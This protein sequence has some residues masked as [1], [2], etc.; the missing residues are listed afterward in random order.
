VTRRV[1]TSFLSALV[2]TLALT[3]VSGAKTWHVP[4]E[5]ATIPA[6]IDSAAAGDTILVASGIYHVNLDTGG[7][8]LVF[9]SEAGAEQTILDG[10]HLNS[11]VKLIGGG[12]IDGFTIQNGWAQDAGSAGDGGGI[13]IWSLGMP[14]P[15]GAVRHC[16]IENN[17]AGW[18]DEGLGGGIAIGPVADFLIY[19][20]LV[21]DNY[22][23]YMGGGIHALGSTVTIEACRVLRNGTHFA[24]GGINGGGELRNNIIAESWSDWWGGGVWELSQSHITII[25]GNTI[26]GNFITTPNPRGGPL[27]DQVL[28]STPQR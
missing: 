7:K 14:R 10:G 3:G 28:P 16:V 1:S 4:L 19:D 22:A 2:A 12:V 13:G 9:L 18:W 25:E 11:V 24:G 23:G 5:V 17:Q 20:C 15:H 8:W 21:Q 27:S 26:V 6:A